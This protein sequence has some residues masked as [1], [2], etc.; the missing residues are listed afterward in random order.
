MAEPETDLGD[1][2]RWSVVQLEQVLRRCLDVPEPFNVAML[3]AELASRTW[4]NINPY[5]PTPD[6][7]A[8]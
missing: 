3:R 6:H 8:S 5:A 7:A 4:Q 1:L 2:T